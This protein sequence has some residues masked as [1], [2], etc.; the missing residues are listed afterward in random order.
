[1]D[2]DDVVIDADS[3]RD[4]SVIVRSVNGDPI[5]AV[6]Y[7]EEFTS[8]DTFKVLPC[9][10]LPVSAYEYYA[11][12]VPLARVP[13][14]DYDVGDYDYK[15]DDDFRSP[16][17]NSAIV[18]VTTEKDTELTITLS[19]NVT[20]TAQDLL[21]QV[22]G[23]MFVEG[24]PVRVSL[25][26]EAQTLYIGSIRDLTGSKVTSNRPI[27]FMSGH[28][29]GTIPVNFEFCDQLL[30]QFPPTAT[31]G[32]TFLTSPIQGRDA[33]DLFKVVASE[34]DTLVTI[35]CTGDQPFQILLLQSGEFSTMN[36]S[37]FTFCYI[38][39]ALPILVVQFSIVSSVDDVIS[40][41]PFMV[42]IPP[43]E[44]YRSSY[45]VSTF[46][47]SLI[48]LTDVNYVNLLV[49]EDVDPSGILLNGEV[50]SKSIE[51]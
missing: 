43:L 6:A 45:Y 47:S 24:V 36:K 12:S 30:E 46:T 34:D 10:S 33:Y 20:V 4:R 19:R 8:S 18:I 50:C 3:I 35:S 48:G 51:P 2:S 28:E 11:V 26:E 22:P 38:Q 23:G 32:R 39:S 29:C 9:V 41:D 13:S 17:G 49:P 31:W 16:E 21:A 27:A 7:A 15:N 42:I 44:Q 1:M 14:P 5:T 40:G 37:S 25:P